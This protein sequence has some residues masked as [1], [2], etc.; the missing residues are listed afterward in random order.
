M[1]LRWKFDKRASQHCIGTKDQ[2]DRLWKV[3]GQAML[4]RLGQ[5]PIGLD[6]AGMGVARLH[7]RLDFCPKSYGYAPF[8]VE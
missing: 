5:R 1:A 6:N 7:I 4:T 2:F 3:V 8:K